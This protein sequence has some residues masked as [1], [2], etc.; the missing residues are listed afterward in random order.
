MKTRNANRLLATTIL[1]VAGLGIPGVSGAQLTGTLEQISPVFLEFTQGVDFVTFTDNGNA[2]EGDV[3]ASLDAIVIDADSGCQASDFAG[4]SSGSIAL[5]ARGTCVFSLKVTNAAA[6]GAV[7]ALIFNNQ[8][9]LLGVQ[10]IDPTTIPALFLDDDLGASFLATLN[11]GA[12]TIH[13]AVAPAQV[14]VPG[15]IGLL[16]I[17][18]AALGFS[19]RKRA[20]NAGG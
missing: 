13:L 12:V 15:T 9:D 17:A 1:F 19:R 11:Q 2:V 16:A 3:T 14:P 5:I 4:F 18:L 20:V 10:L 8:E 6:A 7:G